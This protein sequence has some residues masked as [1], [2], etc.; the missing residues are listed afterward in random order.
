[1]TPIVIGQ[2]VPTDSFLHRLDPR[3]KLVFVFVFMFLVFYA[4]T[5]PSYLLLTLFVLAAVKMARISYSLFFHAVKPILF[6]VLLT[7]LLH[8]LTTKGGEVLLATPV[9]SIH[10]AGVMQAGLMSLRLFIL[11]AIAT[12]LTFTTSPIEITDALEQLLKPLTKVRVPVHELAM[13]M[14]IALRF[15]PTLWGETEKI[16][17]AQM[18]RGVDF[19]SGHLLKRLMSYIP[20]LIPLLI[21]SFRRAEELA[22]AMEARGYRGGEGRSR[23]RELMFAPRDLWL[24]PASMMLWLALW[25]LEK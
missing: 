3:G 14:S 4:N 1:M 22:M 7:S 10:E 11:M 24:I 23:W 16:K 20:I 8:L 17:K 9:F 2:Y 25:L 21:S 18:A 15:I 6:L 12:L 19:E 5:W 13:M